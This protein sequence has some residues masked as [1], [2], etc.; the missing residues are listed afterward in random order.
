MADNQFTS[1]N[2]AHTV[3]ARK[4]TYAQNITTRIW[5][6]TPS[7]TNPY[8]A[9]QAHCHGYDLLDLI[10]QRSFCDV[11]YLLF[12]GELPSAEQA[13]ML[14]SLMVALINP[15]P[16]HP[17]TRAAIN[18]GIGK[19]HPEHMLPIALSVMGGKYLG[20]GDIE[21]S[22]RFIRTSMKKPPKAVAADLLATCDQPDRGDISV[23]PGFGSYFGSSDTL[24][25]NIAN[26][27]SELPGQWDALQWCQQFVAGLPSHHF[28]WLPQGL[29]SAVFCDLGFL[30]RAGVGLYQLISSPGLLAHGLEFANKPI[31][32]IPRVSDENYVIES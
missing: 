25:Q 3:Q 22:M 12:R 15:G 28:G 5:Q 32:A 6:E 2:P 18:A 9:T 26:Q 11:L 7:A 24:T 27:L 14:E 31:T 23:A 13:K 1:D 16:R 29:A 30:P 4:D 17:A 20:A 10:Q 8:V 21:S 19:T